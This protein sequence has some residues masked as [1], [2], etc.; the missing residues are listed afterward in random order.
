[1]TDDRPSGRVI[2]RY[3]ALQVPGWALAATILVWIHVELGL[4]SAAAWTIG[5]LWVAKDI[6][7]FPLTWRA[8]A[9]DL[10]GGPHD[11]V[12]QPGV[13]LDRLTPRGRVRVSGEIWTAV[14]GGDRVPIQAGAAVRVE[15]RE[16]LVLRVRCEDDTAQRLPP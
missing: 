9:G 12:G 10:A 7:L 1:M 5:A 2:V 3:I 4:P 6:A 15:G 13:C 11:P 14:A 8:Y 16:G